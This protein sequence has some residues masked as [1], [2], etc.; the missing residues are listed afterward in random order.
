MNVHSRIRLGPAIIASTANYFELDCYT[1]YDPGLCNS[2]EACFFEVTGV[3]C[4]VGR[5]LANI[6]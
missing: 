1:N 2:P 5:P 3:H 6:G 4:Q